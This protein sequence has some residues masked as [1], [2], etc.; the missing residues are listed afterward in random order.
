[1]F[2]FIYIFYIQGVGDWTDLDIAKGNDLL[3]FAWTEIRLSETSNIKWPQLLRSV[4][5]NVLY[6]GFLPPFIVEIKLIVYRK[7]TTH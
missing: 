1:L 6:S 7:C 5:E 2:F 3:S 4:P